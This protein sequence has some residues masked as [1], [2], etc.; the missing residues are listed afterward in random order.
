ML[1]RLQTQINTTIPQTNKQRERKR[2]REECR[3]F[4]QSLLG[5]SLPGGPE[6]G[7]LTSGAI[8]RHW[9]PC[10]YPSAVISQWRHW[11]SPTH[12]PSTAFRHL[13]PRKDVI[14][15]CLEFESQS[16]PQRS[17]LGPIQL[18]AETAVPDMY[19]TCMLLS[20]ASLTKAAS[21]C[22]RACVRACLRA[23]VR[24]FSI[25]S[26]DSASFVVLCSEPLMSVN[27]PTASFSSVWWPASAF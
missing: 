17:G 15:Q 10:T 5:R 27:L 7:L 16:A 22:V 2:E 25:L 13:P 9:V 8:T 6:C 1:Y 26:T 11:D 21:V 4:S 23:R 24:A 18:T 12:I 3:S 20:S 14:N 19:R